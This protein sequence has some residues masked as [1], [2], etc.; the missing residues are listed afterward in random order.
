VTGTSQVG[1][2]KGGFLTIACPSG[3]VLGG[4]TSNLVTS[5]E[6]LY[7]SYPSGGSTTTGA[8]GSGNGTPPPSGNTAWT[9]F[10]KNN[11]GNNQ[12]I[13]VYAICANVG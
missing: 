12:P 3:H 13:T 8:N 1:S 6:A 7:Q 10:I 2:D 4:G 5:E 11:S 9:V